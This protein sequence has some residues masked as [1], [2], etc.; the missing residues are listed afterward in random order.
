MGYSKNKLK[1]KSF[2]KII[3]VLLILL[4]IA[5]I[6]ILIIAN[7]KDVLTIGEISD[8]ADNVSE[9]VAR[10]SKPIIIDNVI[11]GAVYNNEFVSV[12]KY[13]SY[14]SS[15]VNTEV[16]VY[17]Q[18]GRSGT[19]KISS[20][21]KKDTYTQAVT[22][23][24]NVSEEYIAL[25]SSDV[26]AMPIMPVKVE[27]TDEDYEAVKSALGKYRL[28]NNSINISSVYDVSINLDNTYKIIC[29]TSSDNDKGI[30]SAVIFTNANFTKSKIIKY[31]YIKDKSNSSYW[32][33][34]SFEFAGD[35]NSDGNSEIIIREVNEFEVKYDVL[36]Y[37][38]NLD[39][40]V[41]VLSA[42]VKLE[43]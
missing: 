23:S 24:L 37:D 6:T 17:T 13:L 25:P 11:V 22:S 41:E 15:K 7:G 5:G 28:L 20:I 31:S 19:F 42:V 1:K 36:E 8:K 34:Y 4:L 29:A 21:N 16:N 40:F 18:K 3:F 10:N 30:Y 9:D 12:D 38:K 27:V 14:S 26:S 32:P 43:K 2:L 35:L 39:N 33:I